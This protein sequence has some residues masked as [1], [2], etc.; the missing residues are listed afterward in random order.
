MELPIILK[1][2]ERR[3]AELGWSE[4]FASNKAGHEDG[5]RNIR[6]AIANGRR[7][8]NSNTLKDIAKTIGVPIHELLAPAGAETPKPKTIEELRTERDRLF[9]ELSDVQSQ[10]SVME[11]AMPIKKP[12]KRASR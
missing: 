5:I 7:G 4:H 1:R 11:Q 8:I 9:Q 10:I 2:I 3:L 12:R 6:R